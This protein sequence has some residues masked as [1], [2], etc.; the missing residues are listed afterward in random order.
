MKSSTICRAPI[1]TSRRRTSFVSSLFKN[2]K[3]KKNKAVMAIERLLW[4]YLKYHLCFMTLA[5]LIITCTQHQP[6]QTL[7]VRTAQVLLH[8]RLHLFFVLESVKYM[9]FK[10]FLKIL[11]PSICGS[12]WIPR[13]ASSITCGC[14]RV[15]HGHTAASAGW[16]SV[17]QGELIH[18]W[19]L[20][21]IFPGGMQ[22]P[23]HTIFGTTLTSIS[24]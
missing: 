9:V 21:T 17:I 14:P 4:T 24:I 7:T 6:P 16:S 3:K 5:T 2:I 12:T 23:V 11:T 1:F 10:E 18:P 13:T 8:I 19:D 20:G 22:P 15:V